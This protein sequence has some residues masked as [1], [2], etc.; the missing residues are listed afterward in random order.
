MEDKQSS[1]GSNFME[2]I[3][4]QQANSNNSSLLM[5]V[6]ISILLTAVIT[7]SIVY[8]WQKSVN[9]EIVSSLK[10]KIV[11]LEN[12]MTVDTSTDQPIPPID[13]TENWQTYTNTKYG[14][15]IKYPPSWF[16]YDKDLLV[17]EGR[18]IGQPFEFVVLSPVEITHKNPSTGEFFMAGSLQLV[19]SLGAHTKEKVQGYANKIE[20]TTINEVRVLKW[21]WNVHTEYV[22]YNESQGYHVVASVMN[23]GKESS[24][25]N[26]VIYDQILDT[27]EFNQKN[28]NFR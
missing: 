8:F 9:E 28:Q 4:Q 13:P 24:Y 15:E 12:Q 2:T 1:T 7:G 21:A 10:Q 17:A 22:F 26:D 20:E 18:T 3:T 11:S 19:A 23:K 27:F 25:T 6:T 14:Y 5:T 16:V